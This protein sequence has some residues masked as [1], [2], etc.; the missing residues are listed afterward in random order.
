MKFLVDECLSPELTE[1]STAYCHCHN[2]SGA[3]SHLQ[4]AVG[5]IEWIQWI[6]AIKPSQIVKTS[7]P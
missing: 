2:V 6:Y 5:Q 1:L 4:L 7:F 3:S